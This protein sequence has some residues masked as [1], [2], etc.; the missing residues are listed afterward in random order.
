MFGQKIQTKNSNVYNKIEGDGIQSKL[1][2][3]IFST[4]THLLISFSR[5]MV[6]KLYIYFVVF[7]TTSSVNFF[8]VTVQ[9]FVYK[10]LFTIVF[11]GKMKK[12]LTKPLT[13]FSHID[14]IENERTFPKGTT[15]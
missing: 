8:E 7:N 12:K 2:F 3:K 11:F 5:D 14:F 13:P 6:M 15:F 9:I 1:P 4:L 10:L